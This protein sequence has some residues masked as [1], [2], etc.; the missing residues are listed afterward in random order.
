MGSCNI[1]DESRQDVVDIREKV[2]E[3]NRKKVVYEEIEDKFR[4]MPERS[5]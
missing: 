3:N 5:D 2:K 1:V 4:D